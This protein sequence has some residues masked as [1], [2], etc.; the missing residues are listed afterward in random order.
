[1][2]VRVCYSKAVRGRQLHLAMDPLGQQPTLCI[3]EF[4]IKIEHRFT[5]W[6]R[7]VWR[8]LT[9]AYEVLC[10][11]FGLGGAKAIDQGAIVMEEVTEGFHMSGSSQVT[12][13][14]DARQSVAMASNRRLVSG[15]C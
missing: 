11:Q 2:R 12:L 9:M 5:Q 8:I 1:M 3:D 7:A 6:R 15:N 13:Q 14:P 10:R 4:D